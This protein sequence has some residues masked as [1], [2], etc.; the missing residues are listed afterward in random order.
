MPQKDVYHNTVKNALVKNGWSITSDPLHIKFGG[1]DFYIDLGAE[2]LIG[3]EKDERKI[4]VEVKSF[5]GASTIS[6]FHLAVGQFVNYRLI[7]GHSEPERTLY[8]AVP[9]DIFA[10]FFELPFG[11]LAAQGHQLKIL[12][13]DSEKEVI[14]KWIE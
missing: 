6:E 10:S 14:V 13:F 9:E 1:I 4:A 12:I 11:K 2:T 3:A 7:L 5:I 8:L